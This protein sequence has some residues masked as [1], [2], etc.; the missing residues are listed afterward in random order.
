MF[1]IVGYSHPG[2]K[3]AGKA[4]AYLKGV[5]S[6]G[7]LPALPKNIKLV[8][9]WLKATKHSSLLWHGIKYDWKIGLVLSPGSGLV[10]EIILRP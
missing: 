2:Q 7:A 9:K 3:N 8:M 1:V 4:G 5:Y 10:L 6:Q